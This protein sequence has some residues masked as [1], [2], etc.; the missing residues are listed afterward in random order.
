MGLLLMTRYCSLII[1]S[2]S[3]DCITA[4]CVLFE[5]FIGNNY[6]YKQHFVWTILN[7]TFELI[8]VST[9]IIA[10]YFS[11]SVNNLIYEK[12]CF[13]CHNAI[14]G[15]AQKSLLRN[16]QSQM[17]N[18]LQLGNEYVLMDYK[19]D[20]DQDRND[21]I[22]NGRDSQSSRM[23]INDNGDV[24]SVHSVESGQSSRRAT[25]YFDDDLYI[26]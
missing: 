17:L 10:I 9:Y 12:Y 5:V 7:G 8:D 4:I 16:S 18:E 23:I 3:I 14:Y 22:Y 6:F 25:N 19:G 26:S 13:C 11:F 24:E 20:T 2:A 21:S 15:G 1:I